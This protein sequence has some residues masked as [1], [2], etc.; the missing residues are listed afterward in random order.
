MVAHGATSPMACVRGASAGAARG[1]VRGGRAIDKD[2]P[3]PSELTRVPAP[4]FSSRDDESPSA[5]DAPGGRAISAPSSL[6]ARARTLPRSANARPRVRAPARRPRRRPARASAL[7]LRPAPRRRS[8]ARRADVGAANPRDDDLARDARPTPRPRRDDPRGGAPRPRSAPPPRPRRDRDPFADAYP[9]PGYY[10]SRDASPPPRRGRRPGAAATSSPRAAAAETSAEARA[11]A[12]ASKW[13][14]VRERRIRARVDRWNAWDAQIEAEHEAKTRRDAERRRAATRRR[15]TPEARREALER[16]RDISRSV[17][18][19]Y[20]EGVARRAGGGGN[21]Y[22]RDARNGYYGD[23]YVYDPRPNA[24]ARG[25]TSFGAE[26]G[27]SYYRESY[28]DASS[29]VYRGGTRASDALD[30]GRGRLPRRPKLGAEA[31]LRWLFT[32]L[33]DATRD[34]S[35]WLDEDLDEIAAAS[36]GGGGATTRTPTGI[37]TGFERREGPGLPTA[38]LGRFRRRG[39][40]ARERGGRTT[41]SPPTS[42]RG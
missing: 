29:R 24:K 41:L 14:A 22:A 36:R 3:R 42:S 9:A 17:D 26:Y 4:A 35:R 2:K 19:A 12:E 15:E 31:A 11:S 40:S 13:R 7:P 10:A 32:P 16:Y 6:A 23:P 21:A 1:G 8:R 5:R 25:T 18:A 33:A 28:G 27:G 20:A 37:R 34:A 39:A 30:G 38:P